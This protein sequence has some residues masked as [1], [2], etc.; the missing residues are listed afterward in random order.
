L[1]RP[2]RICTHYDRLSLTWTQPDRIY[3]R[4]PELSSGRIPRRV[5]LYS[6]SLN[7]P[8]RYLDPDGNDPLYIVRVRNAVVDGKLDAT[9]RLIHDGARS[10]VQPGGKLHDLMS[11]IGVSLMLNIM[12]DDPNADIKGMAPANSSNLIL[13]DLGD[14]GS[15][16]LARR[17]GGAWVTR[18]IS[19]M[20]SN[21]NAPMMASPGGHIV[22]IS[23]DRIKKAIDFL[24][25][26]DP[27]WN[28]NT[29]EGRQ[30]II[31]YLQERIAHEA[32]HN[33]GL[34]HSEEVQDVM[35]ERRPLSDAAR[36]RR[37][38]WNPRDLGAVA[39]KLDASRAPLSDPE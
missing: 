17:M 38:S 12:N 31:D 2:G 34:G 25:S 27:T 3:L 13:V 20:E 35:F 39:D 26:R 28:P 18:I 8:L 1:I 37:A 24:A 33:L 21:K 15:K 30:R 6:F 16:D 23:V 9:I 32:G 22:V 11:K 10:S 29:K 19:Q 36:S 5:S 4:S 14:K 7:N